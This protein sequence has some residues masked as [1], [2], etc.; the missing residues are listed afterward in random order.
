MAAFL[1]LAGMVPNGTYEI[2]SRTIRE[3]YANGRFP[4]FIICFRI[5]YLEN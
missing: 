3:P 2:C 5:K 1:G 4:V